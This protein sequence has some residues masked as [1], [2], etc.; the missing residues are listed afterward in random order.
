MNKIMPRD[1]RSVDRADDW[2]DT[3]ACTSEDTDP[4]IFHAGERNTLAT[5]LART[6]CK[7]CPARTACLTNAYAEGDAWGIRAGLTPRQRR[8]ALRRNGGNIAR[9]VA[10]ALHDTTSLLRNIYHH[11]AE[12]A[13]GGHVV[14]TDRRHQILVRQT[15]YTPNQLAFQAHYGRPPVG[16][17]QRTCDVD[18]CV[19]KA[20]LT[21]KPMRLLASARLKAT[22]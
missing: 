22:S 16:S 3:A 13:R 7:R 15:V 14:W 5:E 2:R 19:A 4:E 9:A 18:D 1:T 6:V 11:H 10:D 20:C 8:A 21:D 17:V 12:P